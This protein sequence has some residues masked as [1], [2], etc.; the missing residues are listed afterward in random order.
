MRKLKLR[1]NNNEDDINFKIYLVNNIKTMQYNQKQIMLNLKKSLKN[2]IIL[3]EK[4]LKN[5]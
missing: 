1:I 4:I 2:A 3:K 5:N